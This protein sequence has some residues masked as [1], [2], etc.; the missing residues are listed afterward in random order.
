MIKKLLTGL[1]SRLEFEVNEAFQ[2]TLKCIH[3]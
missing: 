1:F 2:H 3:T